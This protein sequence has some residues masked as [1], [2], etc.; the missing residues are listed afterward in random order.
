MEG[1]IIIDEMKCKIGMEIYLE[2]I[3]SRTS[4]I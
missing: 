3:Y 4:L 1:K 2:N